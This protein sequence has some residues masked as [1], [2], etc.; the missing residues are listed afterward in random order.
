MISTLVRRSEQIENEGV[1]WTD[2]R[3]RRTSVRLAFANHMNRFVASD[4]VPRCPKWG[5]TI[6][7][8]KTYAK[9]RPR[10]P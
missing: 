8:T 2:L 1:Q 5:S 9:V 4:R 6:I 7:R 3:A 10:E